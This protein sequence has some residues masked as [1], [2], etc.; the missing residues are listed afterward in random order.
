MVAP[1]EI[2]AL[3]AFRPSYPERQRRLTRGRESCLI[4]TS[5]LSLAHVDISPP[6]CVMT[7]RHLKQLEVG[8]VLECVLR[9]YLLSACSTTP[10]YIPGAFEAY[11]TAFVVFRHARV[12]SY[13]LAPPHPSRKHAI[14]LIEAGV[15][16]RRAFQIRTHVTE[17]RSGLDESGRRRKDSK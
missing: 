1:V 6:S 8:S 17:T 4:S 12:R 2:Y 5:I 10:R 14:G 11:G 9:G 16:T 7:H 13:P 3:F 15:V